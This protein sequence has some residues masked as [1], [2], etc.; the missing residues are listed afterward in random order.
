MKNQ[1]DMI[2]SIVAIVVALIA[3]GVLYGTKPDPVLPEQSPPVDTT[4][5]TL[6]AVEVPMTNGVGSGGAT[7]G[8]GAGAGGNNRGFAPAGLQGA[9]G[10]GAP[11]ANTG[12]GGAG[13]GGA[14]R[15]AG[16]SAAG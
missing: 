16:V 4:A 1:N 10:G 7:G 13:G 9:G 6:G 12:F 5:P 8:G 15:P 3:L 11:P 2:V 14:P